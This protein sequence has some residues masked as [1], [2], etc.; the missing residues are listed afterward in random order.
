METIDSLIGSNLLKY[1]SHPFA[2]HLPQ[3]PVYRSDESVLHELVRDAQE[4]V[5]AAN[6]EMIGDD[7]LILVSKAFLD[8][9]RYH[10][11]DSSFLDNRKEVAFGCFVALD[12]VGDH[13]REPVLLLADFLQPVAFGKDWNLE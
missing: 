6:L 8:E 4:I 10:D 12:F 13:L 9:L 7:F 3:F 11:G 5:N 1:L 2:N